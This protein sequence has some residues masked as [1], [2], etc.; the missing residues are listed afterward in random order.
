MEVIAMANGQ[1]TT[2][3]SSRKPTKAEFNA[4]MCKVLDPLP[5]AETNDKEI[6]RLTQRANQEKKKRDD[7]VWHKGLLRV[8]L[9]KALSDHYHF[10]D[11]AA[12]LYPDDF[13]MPDKKARGDADRA[14]LSAIDCQFQIPARKVGH[15]RW[16]QEHARVTL[17]TPGFDVS[18]RHRIVAE[19][20]AR[21]APA[22]RKGA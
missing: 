21:L 22:A 5:D 9:A 10:W 14:Y 15:L 13:D 7:A 11:Y 18:H 6:A 20:E 17:S 2:P 4:F 16:K 8:M 1:T 19:D 12:R 3:R